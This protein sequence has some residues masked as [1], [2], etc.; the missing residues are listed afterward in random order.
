MK[1]LSILAIPALLFSSRW[2]AFPTWP[3]VDRQKWSVPAPKCLPEHPA[4]KHSTFQRLFHAP[5]QSATA[6]GPSEGRIPGYSPPAPVRGGG[7]QAAGGRARRAGPRERR[8]AAP[9]GTSVPSRPRGCQA[10]GYWRGG[11]RAVTVPPAV[12]GA[13]GGWQAARPARGR[14]SA[15][16]PA[17]AWRLPMCPG[18]T[19]TLLTKKYVFYTRV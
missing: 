9:C 14:P 10:G 13:Q 18:V 1:S 4:E 8:W 3:P 19:K 5:V 2:A 16:R 11:A 7:R 17:S 12:T 6:T 15:A